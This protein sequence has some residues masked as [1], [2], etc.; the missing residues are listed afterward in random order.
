MIPRIYRIER[1]TEE[2]P[3]AFTVH[4]APNGEDVVSHDFSPGQFNMLYA[5]GAGEVAISMSGQALPGRSHTVHTIRTRGMVTSALARLREGE[6]IGVRGPFGSGWPLAEAANKELLVIAGGLG[7]APLRPVIYHLLNQSKPR[8]IPR[9]RLFY[10]ARRPEEML[11]RSEL[12]AWNREMEVQ[13]SVDH[14]DPSWH[15]NIGVIT[16]PVSSADFDPKGCVAFLCG[17]EAMMRF[18]IQVLMERGVSPADIYISMERNMKCGTGLCGHCQW[19][20]NFICKNGP[21]F[22]YSDVRNW[23]GIRAL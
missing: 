4:L 22:R 11:Y 21:V 6:E 7:L 20:P 12:E 8:P 3:G 14:A 17:P 16:K 18:S 23:L 10:G 5:F 9:F 13:L 2:Y 1:R 19:G 15:G